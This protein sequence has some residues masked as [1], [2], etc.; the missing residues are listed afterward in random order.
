MAKKKK[1]AQVQT[2]LQTTL[3]EFLDRA[4]ELFLDNEKD[5]RRIL[6]GSEDNNIVVNFGMHIDESEGQQKLDTKMR[7]SET[8][9]YHSVCQIEPGQKKFVVVDEEAR[10]ASKEAKAKERASRKKGEEKPEEEDAPK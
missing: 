8:F 3:E 1:T 9:T 4:R 5:I 6:D 7:F 10:A 2:N